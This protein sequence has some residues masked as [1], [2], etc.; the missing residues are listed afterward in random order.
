MPFVEY[1]SKRILYIHVPKT[2]GTTIEQWLTSHAPLHFHTI[3]MPT[4]MKCTPQHLCMQD[5]RLLFG[6]GFFDY[7]FMTVRNPYTRIM[8]EYKMRALIAGKS[9]W[10]SWP[11][12]SLWLEQTL[13]N[14]R[15][16]PFI[17]DNHIRPQWQFT[18]SGVEVFRFEDGME[19][20]LNQ[21]AVRIG[22][23]IP[24]EIPHQLSTQEF[25][26]EVLWDKVDILRIQEFY[27][28]DFQEFGYD[29]RPAEDIQT[30]S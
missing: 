15:K 20:I 1:N 5:I 30:P 29:M 17:M 7:A 14:A 13:N 6:D 12:F 4:P 24:K 25:P 11:T 8:S 3:G 19:S 16:T 26:H 27:A 9:F 21:L 10:K 2:G 23:P 22:A 28:Q 18:G